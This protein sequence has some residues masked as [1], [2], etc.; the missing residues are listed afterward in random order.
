MRN[1]FLIL[2]ALIILSAC[3]ENSKNISTQ[4]NE[5]NELVS[6][7][8]LDSI[9]SKP[10]AEIEKYLEQSGYVFLSN[11]S[12]SDQWKSYNGEEIIQFNG[13]GV[14]VF[15]TKNHGF[16][17]SLVTDIKKSD[18]NS[19]GTSIKNNIE[20]ESYSKEN[21]TILLSSLINPEDRKKDYSLTFLN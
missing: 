17:T 5:T 10:K 8:D 7:K 12:K 15:L 2:L 16:Y 3:K 1:I 11:Q 9:N 18:Y 19:S 4:T 14:L 20:V 21:E 13:K 6:F